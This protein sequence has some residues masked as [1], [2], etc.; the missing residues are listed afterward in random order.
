MFTINFNC[1]GYCR[2]RD[3]FLNTLDEIRALI[4]AVAQVDAARHYAQYHFKRN[5]QYYSGGVEKTIFDILDE[6]AGQENVNANEG[7]ND[8]N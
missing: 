8:R 7:G 2:N 5:M 1:L 3:H 4:C 6:G